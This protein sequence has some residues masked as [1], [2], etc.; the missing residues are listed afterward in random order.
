MPPINV[1]HLRDTHEI[2]GPGKTILETHRAIDSRRFRLHLGVFLRQGETEDSPFIAE[3]RRIE[4]PVHC[5]WGRHAYDIGMVR[6]LV[7]LV[8]TFQIDILHAHEVKSDVI[9]CLAAWFYPIPIVTTLHG[10]IR[11][12]FKHQVLIGLDKRI[13][14]RFDRVIA[15][16]RRIEEDLLAAGV[17]R[18]KLRMVHNAIVV[19]RYQ[20]TGCRG[21]LAE[22]VGGA[23]AR[24][25]IASLGRLSPEKGHADLIAAVAQ[26][27][28]QGHKVSL[29]LI[30]DGPER[31]Q[32]VQQIAALGLQDY[33]RLP[34]Y[35]Q[36]PQRLFEEIDLMVLPSDRKSVV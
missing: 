22:A 8:K 11:H 3:A 20:R 15:V 24:P 19:E 32:L 23:L 36:A 7:D 26:V 2:G 18:E 21:V 35:I 31:P 10:W 17:P 13:A 6:Q 28:S 4:M 25:V 33:V 12:N 34:G 1:L 9:A 30:G 16:S 27:I 29:V 5:I 14:K